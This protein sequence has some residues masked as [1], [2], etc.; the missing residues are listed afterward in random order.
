MHLYKTH[1][2]RRQRV[3]AGF[4]I[5]MLCIGIVRSPLFSNAA[6]PPVDTGVCGD[7]TLDI[8]EQC[9]DGNLVNGDGCTNQ[10]K[11]EVCGNGEKTLGEQCDDGNTINGDGCSATCYLEFCGDG[12]TQEV[13]GEQCDD[14]NQ[15]NGDGCSAKCILEVKEE[16]CDY[17]KE[18]TGFLERALRFYNSITTPNKLFIVQHNWSTEDLN[19]VKKMITAWES[20]QVM[21][22]SDYKWLV[23]LVNMTKLLRVSIV[24]A[25]PVAEEVMEAQVVD[26]A[27]TTDPEVMDE[28]E[29]TEIED[30]IVR[31]QIFLQTKTGQGV[32]KRIKPA[33]QEKIYTILRKYSRGQKLTIRELREV[34]YLSE[35]LTIALKQEEEVYTNLVK[36]LIGTE[37][38]TAVVHEN[39]LSPNRLINVTPSVAVVELAR[40]V[41]VLKSGELNKAA[42]Q[43]IEDMVRQKLKVGSSLLQPGVT[44]S[45]GQRPLEA[46]QSLVLLK[47]FAEQFATPSIQVSAVN[48][49]SEAKKIR[50]A[51]PYIEENYGIPGA[52]IE[53]LIRLIETRAP[54]TDTNNAER[55]VATVNRIEKIL[56]RNNIAQPDDIAVLALE[57]TDTL[58]RAD[59]VV[60]MYAPRR[61]M[62]SLTS[63]EESTQDLLRPVAARAEDHIRMTFSEGDDEAQREAIRSFI[64]KSE[65]VQELRTALGKSDDAAYRQLIATIRESET[66]SEA[67]DATNQYLEYLQYAVHADSRWRSF[68]ASIQE[69]LGM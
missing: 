63:T 43:V 50:S 51:L 20:K 23:N 52:E 31:A 40:A 7:G 12:H 6:T 56:A 19:F 14:G 25:V 27:E 32:F 3:A 13:S 64:E 48:I 41:A 49:A 53:A 11:N 37:I 60:A 9:D 28:T 62:A 21:L 1:I 57:T 54:L 4:A 66:I 10:C 67:I 58:A 22:C 45:A 36:R 33:D 61:F 35:Q 26:I 68:V 34:A 46:F 5:A 15:I 38:G 39:Q 24:P 42:N 47:E 8:G 59:K 55:F 2:H 18:R 69:F 29:V 44:F 16:I 17:D 65:R 30:P